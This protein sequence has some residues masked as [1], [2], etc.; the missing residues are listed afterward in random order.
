MHINNHFTKSTT[1]KGK[2]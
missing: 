2:I 1:A